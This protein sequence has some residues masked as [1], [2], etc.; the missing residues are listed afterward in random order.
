MPVLLTFD[1]KCVLFNLVL[2]DRDF[3]TVIKRRIPEDILS[4]KKF[5][6]YQV[7]IY[8]K[9]VPNLKK[10]NSIKLKIYFL[11]VCII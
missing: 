4:V 2:G 7:G 6:P 5:M 11:R 1:I 10:N 9:F 3:F 8:G